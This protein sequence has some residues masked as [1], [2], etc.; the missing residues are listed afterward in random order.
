MYK[1]DVMVVYYFK[2][3]T[4]QAWF[5]LGYIPYTHIIVLSF[6]LRSSYHL[7]NYLRTI[8]KTNSL[9]FI[10]H[11]SSFSSLDSVVPR[12]KSPLVLHNM[13]P[14]LHILFRN[15]LNSVL[16]FKDVLESTRRIMLKSHD[17]RSMTYVQ[18][19]DDISSSRNLNRV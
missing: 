8:L 18:Y 11:H 1:S 19:F 14:H 10:T 15:L 12:V 13:F 9:Y 17:K 3:L 7:L 16:V 6:N 2:P 4:P 5:Y